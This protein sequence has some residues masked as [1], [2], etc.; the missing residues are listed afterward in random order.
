MEANDVKRGGSFYLQSKFYRAN[1]LLQEYI[2]EQQAKS[3]TT[4]GVPP[5]PEEEEP[6]TSTEPEQ[7]QQQKKD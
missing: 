7:E 4:A 3:G 1:E 5:K 2:A 6:S